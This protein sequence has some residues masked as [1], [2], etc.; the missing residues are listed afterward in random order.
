MVVLSVGLLPTGGIHDLFKDDELALDQFSYIKEVDE[1]IEPA[2]T[3]VDGVY[4][5][6]AASAS[7]DIPDTIFHS[8]AAAAQ[9][10]AYLKKTGY[11]L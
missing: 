11:M 4:V 5:A 10:A 9:V 3:S 7:R 1:D 6:G 2:K 8:G